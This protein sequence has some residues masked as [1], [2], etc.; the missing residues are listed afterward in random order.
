MEFH[1]CKG[2]QSKRETY[3]PEVSCTGGRAHSRIGPHSDKEPGA[4]G[5]SRLQ[6]PGSTC[7]STTDGNPGTGG[8]S[9]QPM[10]SGPSAVIQG[11]N[12]GTSSSQP[13]AMIPMNIVQPRQPT[14]SNPQGYQQYTFNPPM[15]SNN[16]Q[17]QVGNV[18]Q[19]GG[20]PTGMGPG[21]TVAN[22]PPAP[23]QYPH[24][25]PSHGIPGR[26]TRPSPGGQQTWRVDGPR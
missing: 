2:W 25:P 5:S 11:S 24:L 15:T 26:R 8:H 10:A 16:Q 20:Q 17:S 3:R 4:T 19:Q 6:C 1:E 7:C 14:A 22:A 23:A 21:G 13:Q 18:M 9:N 12:T